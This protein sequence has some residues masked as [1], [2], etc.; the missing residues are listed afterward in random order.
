MQIKKKLAIIGASYLQLPLVKKAKEMGLETYCFAWEEGSVCRDIADNFYPISILEKDKILDVCREIGIDG[1]TTIA[2]DTAI[3]TV[4]YV[5]CKLGLISNPDQ[6]SEITTNKYLMRRCFA[7]NDIPSPKFALVDES[8]SYNIRGF[9]FP[10][11]VKPTDRSGSRGVEKV[12]DPV[13]LESAIRRA[14]NESFEHKAIIDYVTLIKNVL[15]AKR[16]SASMSSSSFGLLLRMSC[17]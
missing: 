6:Y 4:N 16:G 14:Q 8:D 1:I 13:L 7:E 15:V 9:K 10:L 3:V 5:A 2:S 17:G 11:I 12:L